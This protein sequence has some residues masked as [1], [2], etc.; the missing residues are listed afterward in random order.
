MGTEDPTGPISLQ[1]ADAAGGVELGLGV[2]FDSVDSP[3]ADR[4]KNISIRN[5]I[6]LITLLLCSIFAMNYGFLTRKFQ[7]LCRTSAPLGM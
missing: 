3:Q 4:D 6:V 2:E 1:L 7:G 5:T